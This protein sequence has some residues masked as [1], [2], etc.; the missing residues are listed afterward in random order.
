MSI[1]N[2]SN[3]VNPEN[4]KEFRIARVTNRIKSAPRELAEEMFRRWENGFDALWG[5][6]DGFGFGQQITVAEKLAA[7]GTDAA[8]LFQLNSEFTIFMLT[9]L[10]GKRDDLVARINEKLATIPEHVINEDGAVALVEVQ[11]VEAEE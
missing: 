4:S 9:Q 10:T 6:Q 5:N 7:L 8:E 2:Q 11:E 1:L 3:S